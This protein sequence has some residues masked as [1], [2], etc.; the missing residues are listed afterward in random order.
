MDLKFMTKALQ[1]KERTQTKTDSSYQK[2]KDNLDN[3]EREVKSIEVKDYF[4]YLK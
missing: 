4:K 2:N 3:K 1:D